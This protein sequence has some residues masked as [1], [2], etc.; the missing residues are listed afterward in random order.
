MQYAAIGP[1]AIHLPETVEDND[2]LQAQFPQV[3]TWT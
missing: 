1:I 2:L 3:G